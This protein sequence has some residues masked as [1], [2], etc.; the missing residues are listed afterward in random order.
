[1]KKTCVQLTYFTRLPGS[2]LF[3]YIHTHQQSP[4]LYHI[5]VLLLLLHYEKV[6]VETC[7]II[8]ITIICI[9]LKK[10]KRINEI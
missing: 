6:F 4:L 1:M 9:C 5:L 2:L 10:R 7:G 3:L 8:N